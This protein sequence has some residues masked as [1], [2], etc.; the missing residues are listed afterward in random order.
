MRTA[1]VAAALL[2]A[3]SVARAEE[4]PTGLPWLVGGGV[5]A[6]LGV[7]NLGG[8]PLCMGTLPSAQRVPCAA[9]S[10]AFGLAGLAVGV[11]LL[12][13]GAQKRQRWQT[14]HIEGRREGAVLAW[15]ATW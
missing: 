7:I 3:P 10:I 6:G 12:V 9:T 5:A 13:V 1:L 4:P 2:L 8:A 14:W 11:P 15:S